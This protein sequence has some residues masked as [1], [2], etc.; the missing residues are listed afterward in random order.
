MECL[1]VGIS[2]VKGLLRHRAISEVVA[3][4][5][6]AGDRRATDLSAK[7]SFS[8]ASGWAFRSPLLID[9]MI[10]LSHND[11]PETRKENLL[12]THGQ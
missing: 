1:T 3:V 8:P 9:I 4:G 5:R 12:E 11:S 7:P 2:R 6:K 10:Y